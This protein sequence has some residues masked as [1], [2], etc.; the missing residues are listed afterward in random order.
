MVAPTYI[1][2]G[3]NRQEKSD[4]PF[5]PQRRKERRETSK[6]VRKEVFIQSREAGDWIKKLRSGKRLEKPSLAKI[7][8]PCCYR[9]IIQEKAEAIQHRI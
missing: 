6:R 1:R 8:A 3:R 9:D 5:S 2:K 4:W 7:P